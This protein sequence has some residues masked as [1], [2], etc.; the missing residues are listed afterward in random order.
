MTRKSIPVDERTRDRVLAFSNRNILKDQ[1]YAEALNELLDGFNF[2]QIDD[3]Y[4]NYEIVPDVAPPSRDVPSKRDDDSST[5][6]DELAAD[7]EESD[8]DDVHDE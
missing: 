5:G 7:S 2:P 3:I 1:S 8:S 4:Q 6:H